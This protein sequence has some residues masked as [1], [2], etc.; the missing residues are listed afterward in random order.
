MNNPQ[1]QQQIHQQVAE[2]TV[3]LDGGDLDRSRRGALDG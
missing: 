1:E 3:R 2:R